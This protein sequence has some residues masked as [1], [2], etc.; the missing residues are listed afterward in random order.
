MT[1]INEVKSAIKW[2]VIGQIIKIIVGLLPTLCVLRYI[3]PAEYG[4]LAIVLMIYNGVNLFLRPA[5][6]QARIY[7]PDSVDN[8]K[9]DNVIFSINLLRSCFII[10][11]LYAVLPLLNSYYE[12]DFSTLFH[13]LFLLSFTSAFRS[14]RIYELARDLRIKESVIFEKTCVI[15]NHL[16]ALVLVIIMKDITALLIGQLIGGACRVI[17]SQY[18]VP[19]KYKFSINFRLLKPVFSFGA[20]VTIERVVTFISG[21]VDRFIISF[22][23]GLEMLGFYEIARVPA[24][25]IL[26]V[27][28]SLSRD[29]LFP[30]F[31]KIKQQKYLS[32]ELIKSYVGLSMCFSYIGAVCLPFII[33]IFFNFLGSKWLIA[34]STAIFFSS[35]LL[36]DCITHGIVFGIFKSIGKVKF[37]IYYSLFEI[38][39]VSL[40]CLVMGGALGLI[41]LSYIVVGIHCLLMMI[42]LVVLNR[43]FKQSVDVRLYLFVVITIL[44]FVWIAYYSGAMWCYTVF[45]LFAV[46]YFIKFNHIINN[47]KLVFSTGVKQYV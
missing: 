27:I 6:G 11:A 18:L 41:S 4:K 38:I 1:L 35:L 33:P 45:H 34:S 44:S 16:C 17:G 39:G 20:L 2:S 7:K 26:S 43:H 12:K 37:S 42:N 30:I 5:F 36:T 10:I 13:I 21:T 22:A 24:S 14:P 8:E 28:N 47:L 19:Y 31:S 46:L 25:K 40:G 3:T 32:P 9:V 29:T 15:I 23:F